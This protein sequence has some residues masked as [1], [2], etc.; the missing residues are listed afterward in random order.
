[1]TS[2]GEEKEESAETSP[3]WL[4]RRSIEGKGS[5]FEKGIR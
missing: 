5:I 2:T 3:F 4:N 1:M